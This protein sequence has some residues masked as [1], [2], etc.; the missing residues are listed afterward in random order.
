[1]PQKDI[2]I[3]IPSHNHIMCEVKRKCPLMMTLFLRYMR[4]INR[5][6]DKVFV[7]FVFQSLMAYRTS[8]LLLSAYSDVL[9][10]NEGC[11]CVSKYNSAVG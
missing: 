8:A 6:S 7:C 2:L 10:G 5:H 3:C 9:N 4:I 1:M 11:K